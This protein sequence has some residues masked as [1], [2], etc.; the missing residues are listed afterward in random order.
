[1]LVY[2]GSKENQLNPKLVRF[3]QDKK[4]LK[5]TLF[6]RQG[7]GAV[8]EWSTNVDVFQKVILMLR[9]GLN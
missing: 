2:S 3:R 5:R 6:H 4:E 9:Q 7:G 8:A 1:M